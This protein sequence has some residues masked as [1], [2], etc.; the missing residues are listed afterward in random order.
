[1]SKSV[2]FRDVIKCLEHVGKGKYNEIT[3]LNKE[4]DPIVIP[5]LH[6]L[7]IDVRKAI[8]VDA[9]NHRDMDMNIRIGFRYNGFMRLDREW[10]N[11]KVTS[12]HE[13]IAIA[14]ARDISLAK[15]MNKMSGNSVS[16][17]VTDEGKYELEDE[18]DFPLDLISETYIEDRAMIETL[19]QLAI[20][21]RGE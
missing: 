1:M 17:V 13:R 7:G 5:I 15:E 3:L 18:R 6:E 11:S 19:N 20:S 2:S 12:L 9:A 16:H 4:S 14:A 21:I 10:A 8:W